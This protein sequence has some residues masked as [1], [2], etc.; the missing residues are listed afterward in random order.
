MFKNAAEE[1]RGMQPSP[2]AMTQL[3]RT[4]LTGI[5]MVGETLGGGQSVSISAKLGLVEKLT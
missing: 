1:P 2:Q 5:F 3:I 4:A